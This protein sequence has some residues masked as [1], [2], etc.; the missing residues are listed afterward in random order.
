M[1]SPAGRRDLCQKKTRRNCAEPVGANRRASRPTNYS[2][3][4]DRHDHFVF[5]IEQKLILAADYNV[6]ETR[7]EARTVRLLQHISFASLNA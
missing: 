3:D 7:S 2:V 4:A 5:S 6:V 1:P